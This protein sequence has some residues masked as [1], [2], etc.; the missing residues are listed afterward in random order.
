[1]LSQNLQCGFCTSLLLTNSPV[2]RGVVHTISQKPFQW[3]VPP[4][5]FLFVSV[6]SPDF[7]SLIF[8]PML[9]PCQW[10][11]VP[12]FDLWLT[13]FSLVY[14]KQKVLG[15]KACARA[16][17]YNQR[18]VFPVHSLGGHSIRYAATFAILNSS[19]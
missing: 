9:T 1:M 4:S 11:L 12:P 14:S 13:L 17:P 15:F 6:R 5:C 8:F 10:L 7:L 16:E 19:L 3:N 2:V 18:Q